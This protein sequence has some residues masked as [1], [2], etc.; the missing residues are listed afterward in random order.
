M[1]LLR[2][3]AFKPSN[4]AASTASTEKKTLNEAAA[5]A[6]AAPA[7]AVPPAPAPA[8]VARPPVEA[9]A[10][11]APAP[12]PAGHR[13]AVVDEPR[14]AEPRPGAAAEAPARVVGVPIRVQPPP[15]ARDTP[16]ADE[17]RST[18]TPIP[19]SEDGDFWYATV[20]Q[21]IAAEA[22]AALARELALQSQLVGRDTDQWLL[23]IERE[24]LNQPSSREKL[25]AA[26]GGLGHDVKLAIEIG[27]VVDSPAR[28]NKQAADERQR[29]AEEAILSDPEVQALMRDF[30]AKIVPG[31][32][33][34]A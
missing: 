3:L 16:R 28:R 29:V 10:A 18:F 33:K 30:D 21:L 7:R 25:T 15:S 31:T 24:T 32:L 13:L 12:V 34:P 19:T 2:L 1:V 23:R 11:A 17:P 9:P 14:Q 22:I 8:P 4:A 27:S 6:P 5:V 26:L 20:S